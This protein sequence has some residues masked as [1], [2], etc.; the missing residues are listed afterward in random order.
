MPSVESVILRREILNWRDRHFDETHNRL[1]REL[2]VL[3]S[4]LDS[5]IEKMEYKD[6]ILNGAEYSKLHLQPVYSS[7]AEREIK[8]IVETAETD[9]R[10][11]STN[12]TFQFTHELR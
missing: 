10:K 8:G 3:F 5:E 11:L 1:A 7:W 12:K 2:I 4:A 9:L 6:I